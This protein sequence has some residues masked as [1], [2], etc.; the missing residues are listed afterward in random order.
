MPVGIAQVG[1]VCFGTLADS[2]SRHGQAHA[3]TVTPVL[4]LVLSLP[5]TVFVPSLRE[6][7]AARTAAPG[8]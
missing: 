4:N 5:A 8:A 7:A 2:T 6:A 3:F 1:L